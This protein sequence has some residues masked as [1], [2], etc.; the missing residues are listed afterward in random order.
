[1]I[2]VVLKNEETG[3]IEKLGRF[4]F[5]KY[6]ESLTIDGVWEQD[7]ILNS[8]QDDGLLK[9][10]S[11]PEAKLIARQISQNLEKIAA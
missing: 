5:G 9:E 2:Y 8:Q 10:I 4:D 1:M 6:P 7:I 11:S 3:E